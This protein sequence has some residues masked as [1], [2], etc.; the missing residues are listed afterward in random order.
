MQPRR[1]L[2]REAAP[3]LRVAGQQFAERAR[4]LVR[5]DRP[6]ARERLGERP[7]FEEEVVARE[8]RR[9]V[10]DVGLGSHR[11]DYRR[12]ALAARPGTRMW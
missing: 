10:E 3:F 4:L 11:P 8:P 7:V 5:P 6:L 2:V 12:S 9:L 1:A